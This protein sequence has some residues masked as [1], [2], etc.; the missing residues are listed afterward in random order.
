MC[1]SRGARETPVRSARPETNVEGSGGVRRRWWRSS[2]RAKEE[3]GRDWA[4]REMRRSDLASAEKQCSLVEFGEAVE[5]RQ[6][7]IE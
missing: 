5:Q 3:I 2:G 4:G 1:S 7:H 6:K